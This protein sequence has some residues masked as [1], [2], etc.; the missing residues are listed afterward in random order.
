MITIKRV[1]DAYQPEDGAR[2]LVDRL[3]PRGIRK[4]ALKMDAWLKEAAPSQELRHWFHHDP[5]LWEDF[6]KRYRMELDR[7]PEV[8][9]PI[10]KAVQQG[11][12]TLLYS[13]RDTQHN[14][15]AVLKAYLEE[16]LK[17]KKSR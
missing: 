13:A 15:A 9:E 4:E 7:H 10:L 8:L 17:A 14:S 6:K 12:V 1:Y 11:D 5:E 3:W 16:H 2:F